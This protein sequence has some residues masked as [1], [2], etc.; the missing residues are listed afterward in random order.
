MISVFD[1][2]GVG[3]TEHPSTPCGQRSAPVLHA[4]TACLVACDRVGQSDVGLYKSDD[5][6][7]SLPRS[8]LGPCT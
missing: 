4:L 3:V 5:R 2:G 7:L 8:I 6:W 1:G